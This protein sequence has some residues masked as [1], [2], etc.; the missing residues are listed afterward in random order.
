M[1]ARIIALLLIFAT[2]DWVGAQTPF[3]LDR[4]EVVPLPND[5]ASFRIDGQERLRWHFGD[6]YPRPFFYPLVGPSGA[7]LTRMGH[8]GAQNHDHHRSIWFAHQDVNGINFW[9]DQTDARVRQT[10]WYRYRDGDDEAIMATLSIWSDGQG[11]KLMEQDTV[12][13]L[14]PLDAGEHALE[15][16]LTLRPPAGA[17]VVQ[18]G[19]TNFGFLAVRV[20]KTIAAYFGGGTITNSEGQVG[21]P[22]VFA[23][24]ARW[25]D[26]SGPVV[27]GTGRERRVEI[28]GI[29]YFDHPHNPRYP[30]HWHVR[31]DGWMGA[32]FCMHESYTIETDQPLILRYLLYAHSGS[33]NR[34]K[35]HAI[36]SAFA[37]RPGFTIAKATTR[38]L[39]F[40]VE[41]NDR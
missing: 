33:Y 3:Q 21:E 13:A 23:K 32:S 35:V 10:L 31:E 8:P 26:Y 20:A 1:S 39:Q 18:L 29:T 4:C 30:A 5:Q 6:Q 7:T 2:A 24:P 38:H 11:R 27:L 37:G 25:V 17:A 9:S 16:Q 28:E 36:H 22:D 19:K 41:R 12:A 15:I 40:E 34:E 14:I